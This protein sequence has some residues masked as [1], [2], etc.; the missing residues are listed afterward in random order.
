MQSAH[1]EDNEQR[2]LY[3]LNECSKGLPLQVEGDVGNL[4]IAYVDCPQGCGD[5]VLTT[6]LDDH[7]LAHN[8]SHSRDGHV[9]PEK[10]DSTSKRMKTSRHFAVGTRPEQPSSPS[11]EHSLRST[12]ASSSD[13]RRKSVSSV[14]RSILH[15]PS[16]ISTKATHDVTA[17]SDGS[18]PK[19]LGVC[20]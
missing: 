17:G 13:G 8:I 14:W 5:L 20:V 12:A 6:Q 10:N 11:Q 3:D 4:A 1:P 16:T 9:T 15:M 7:L 18:V 19:R 2:V